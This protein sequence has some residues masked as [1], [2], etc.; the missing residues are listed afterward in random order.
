MLRTTHAPMARL[1]ELS[2]SCKEFQ[3]VGCNWEDVRFPHFYIRI[4][5]HCDLTFLEQG[6]HN[7]NKIP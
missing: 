1:Q 3:R 4:I 6:S 5:L 7:V 2:L